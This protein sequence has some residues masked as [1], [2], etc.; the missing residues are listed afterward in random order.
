VTWRGAAPAASLVAAVLVAAA[1]VAWPAAVRAQAAAPADAPAPMQAHVP[2]T[3]GDTSTIAVPAIAPQVRLAPVP[4]LWAAE[5]EG[6]VVYLLG[7][8]HL[9]APDDYPLATEVDAAFADAESLLFEMPPAEMASP[10]LAARMAQAALRTDGTRLDAELPE[11]T[12]RK[13]DDWV[14]AN[15]ARL[16]GGGITAQGLQLFEP[17]FA[18][19]VVGIVGMADAGLDPAL[20]LDRHFAA[21]AAAAGKPADGFETGDQQIAFLDGMDRAEQLQ[22]LDEA[23]SDAMPGSDDNATLHAQWRAGD[24]DGMWEKLGGELQRDYPRLY[25]RIDVARNTAWLAVIEQR[26]QAPGDDD[27]LV[28]VGALHLLGPDGLVERLRAAGYEVRRICAAC[29]ATPSP[30]GTSTMQSTGHA[31]THSSQ[32]VHSGST[33]ACM[34]LAPPTIA[35][36]GQAWMHLVQ[37]MQSSSTTSA[38]WAGLCSPRARSKGTAGTPSTRARARAPASPPGGQRSGPASPRAMASA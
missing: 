7:S 23:L 34:S 32:P 8:F 33:T 5:H 30:T 11:A 4:L 35:S 25:Q 20:G 36:T 26:L 38:T 16:A 12:R 27:T 21:A 10:T 15:A 6:H 14:R 37:P 9:L 3:G 2:A 24:V 13:L 19:L 31:G 22:F 17:W 18:G 28:V 1:L 29:D